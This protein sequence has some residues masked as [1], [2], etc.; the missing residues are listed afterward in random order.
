MKTK[1]G[2]RFFYDTNY[3]RLYYLSL[4]DKVFRIDRNGYTISAG[5][6]LTYLLTSSNVIELVSL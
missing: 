5:V 6:E 1:I 2:K 3:D 4:E